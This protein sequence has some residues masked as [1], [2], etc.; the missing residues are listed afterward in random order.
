MNLSKSLLIFAAFLLTSSCTTNNTDDKIKTPESY[1]FTRNGE[2]TVSF[3]G[4]TTRIKMATELSVAMTDFDNSTEELLL[5]MYRNQTTNGGDA[6]PYSDPELNAATKSVKS[7]VAAS[8]D[9]YSSNTATSVELKNQFETWISAQINEVFPNQNVEAQPG[10]AGQIADGTSTRYVSAKGFEYNQMLAKGLIGALM[11]DQILNNYVSVSVLDAG[12][13]VEDNNNEVVVDGTAYTNMEHNW[14]EAFGYLYGNSSNTANPNLTIGQDDSFLNAYVGS[15]ESD[16]DFAGIAQIIFD[17]FALGRA[18]IVEGDYELRDEQ[19]EILRAQI[20]AIIGIRAVYYLQSGK[21]VLEQANPDFGAAFHDLSE[22]YGFVYS[23]Q[24]TRQPG[25]GQS[26]FT[27]AEVDGF[28]SLLEAGNGL[29]DATPQT[30][31]DISV[32][33]ASKFDFTIEEAAN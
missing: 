33:I 14:D 8:T 20:S 6:N 5:E 7:K 9:F 1:E 22:A 10:I 31:Q 32:D 17:A 11:A 12:T 27:K 30:L 16:E 2:S 23:L 26:Y 21:T 15:V 25:T 24:F 19:A 18:A 28:I 13:N 3:S 4:Q 29:W